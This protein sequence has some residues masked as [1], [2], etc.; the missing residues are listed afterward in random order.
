MTTRK[1]SSRRSISAAH[2]RPRQKPSMPPFAGVEDHAM[3]T[4][5]TLLMAKHVTVVAHAITYTGLFAGT[6]RPSNKHALCLDLRFARFSRTPSPPVVVNDMRA[7]NARRILIPLSSLSSVTA[8]VPQTLP[9]SRPHTAP[10]AT[11]TPAFATDA[12]IARPAH[13]TPRQLKRFDHFDPP[14]HPAPSVP[15]TTPAAAT[16]DEQTFGHLATNAARARNWDQF[17]VNRDKFGVDPT[18]DETQYTTKIDRSGAN[19]EQREREAQ[20]MADE[21]ESTESSN[22]HL[23]EERNQQLRSDC[24]EDARF[25][26]VQRSSAPNLPKS[27]PSLLKSAPSL[28]KPTAHPRRSYLAAASGTAEQPA[29]PKSPAPSSAKTNAPAAPATATAA[30]NALG[31]SPSPS[32]NPGKHVPTASAK[33][34]NAGGH[35]KQHSATNA[36]HS[37]AANAKQHASANAKHHA[38]PKNSH[39]SSKSSSAAQAKSP[40]ADNGANSRDGNTTTTTTNTGKS[41]ASTAWPATS[42][43]PTATAATGKAK[44]NKTNN[45]PSSKPLAH[46]KSANSTKTAS[47][48]ASS[49][50]LSSSPP[51]HGKEP[52]QPARSA[53]APKAAALSANCAADKERTPN[54]KQPKPSAVRERTGS[55]PQFI[56]SRNYITGRNSPNQSRNSP[57]PTSSVADTS[58]VGVL[59]LDAQTPNLGPEQIKRFE[60]YKTNREFQSIAANREKITDDLKKFSTQLDS[61]NGSIR[62]AHNNNHPSQT[63]SR[64]SS[65]V[66]TSS[67]SNPS[68]NLTPEKSTVS[69]VTSNSAVTSDKNN[70]NLVTTEKKQRSKNSGIDKKKRGE[71]PHDSASAGKKSADNLKSSEEPKHKQKPK[72]KL[73]PNAQEFK[74]NPDAPAF[75]PGTPKI[76]PQPSPAPPAAMMTSFPPGAVAPPEFSQPM[77]HPQGYAVAM[78]QPM[79]HMPYAAQPYVVMSPGVHAAVPGSGPMGYPYI[80]GNQMGFPPG[81]VPGRY[82]PSPGVPVSYGGVYPPVA[83]IVMAQGPQRVP[84]SAYYYNPGP[85]A[86]VQG[87]NPSMPHHPG[88]HMF[89]QHQMGPGPGQ[90]QGGMGGGPRG[91]HGTHRRG[92]P[93]KGRGKQYNSHSHGH[94]N[95]NTVDRQLPT[96]PHGAATSD[97]GAR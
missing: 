2:Q 17:Q 64:V 28:P 13:R 53:A 21:I 9:H 91:P 76:T 87:G 43:S 31:S 10:P 67:T 52:A 40:P 14:A 44:N 47:P 32:P 82:P 29:P 26:S 58:A 11:T 45:P 69:N 48:N 39:A 36:K 63:I 57:M 73:N 22:I 18:F 77:P 86:G 27:A 4:V 30:N 20:R 38:P 84:S 55:L 79:A 37:S 96:S 90:M 95:H 94:P 75:E 42:A 66:S 46:T 8:A 51:P 5:L 34:G 65:N 15:A 59:N 54:E 70:N 72:F 49:S 88:Q 3:I 62:R 19:F 93:G 85:Y 92:G 68:T 74:F 81:P 25:S 50:S 6:H 12:H 71:K 89:P 23:R 56:K 60:E 1:S 83:P 97:T 61:R 7:S 33:A 41:R 16:V 35:A 24:D 80:Q 78:Q